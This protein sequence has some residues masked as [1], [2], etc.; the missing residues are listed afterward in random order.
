VKD[1]TVHKATLIFALFYITGLSFD[2][3]SEQLVCV[4]K[5]PARGTP[6]G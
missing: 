1:G 3:L 4:N 6:W 5:S 2:I